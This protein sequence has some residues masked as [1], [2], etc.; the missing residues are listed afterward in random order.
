MIALPL[1][2]FRRLLTEIVNQASY[3]KKRT[4]VK[5]NGKP[6]FAIVP[7]EDVQILLEH[8]EMENRLDNA[9]A[10]KALAEGDFVELKDFLAELEGDEI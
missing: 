9:E 1:T 3:N 2:E 10:E 8:E 7:M 4:V 6:A 5:R